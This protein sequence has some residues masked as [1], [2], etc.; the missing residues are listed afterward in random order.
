MFGAYLTDRAP[1]TDSRVRKRIQAGAPIYGMS[2]DRPAGAVRRTPFAP[3]SPEAYAESST[4]R[5][6]PHQAGA[7]TRF[8]QDT[9]SIYAE[10]QARL[11]MWGK[12]GGPISPPNF[13]SQASDLDGSAGSRTQDAILSFQRWANSTSDAGLREDGQLD[14]VTL[15]QIFLVTADVAQKAAAGTKSVWPLWL[16]GGGVLALV[17]YLEYGDTKRSR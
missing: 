10:A 7:P 17:S 12:S 9:G 2:P 4:L 1:L 14:D 16:L 15:G 5:I 11:V 8:V 6:R 13:G 3:L